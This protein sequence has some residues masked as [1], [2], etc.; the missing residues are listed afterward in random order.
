M[1]DN[2]PFIGITMCLSPAPWTKTKYRQVQDINAHKQKYMNKK[3]KI[4]NRGASGRK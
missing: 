3:N 2:D 4:E 1:K